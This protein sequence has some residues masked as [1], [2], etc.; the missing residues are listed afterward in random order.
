[1]V[2]IA[3]DEVLDFLWPMQVEA[4]WGVG[5]ASAARLHQLGVTTVGQL[6]ALPR[7]AVASALGK[8]A[9]QLVHSLAWGQRPPP[10]CA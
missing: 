3:D 2:V 1:M 10:G 9:G 8:S 7:H 4:L 5:P 6:A